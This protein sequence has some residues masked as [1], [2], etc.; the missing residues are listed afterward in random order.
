MNYIKCSKFE[1]LDDFHDSLLRGREIVFKYN[2]KESNDLEVVS[3]SED[4]AKWDTTTS[5]IS[6]EPNKELTYKIFNKYAIKLSIIKSCSIIIK[7]IF[8]NL[9]PSRKLRNKIR[10]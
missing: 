2:G 1:D 8:L 9:I 6:L 4:L 10:G 7:K 5:E 3:S